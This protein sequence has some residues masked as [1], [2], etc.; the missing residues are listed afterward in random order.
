MTPQ[1]PC[2]PKLDTLLARYL[3]RRTDAQ[4]EGVA[5]FD[6]GE[7]TPYDSG[8]VQPVDAKLAWDEAKAAISAIA[9]TQGGAATKAPAGWSQL[10][11]SHEPVV[12]LALCVGN[13]P[14]LVRNFHQILHK[15]DLTQLRP[16]AGRTV[17]IP[18]VEA[19][20]NKAEASEKTSQWLLALG[21][22]RLSKQFDAADAFIERNESRIP[23][24]DRAA[25]ENE[26]A[27]LAWHRGDA[28]KAYDIWARQEETV[29]VLFNRGM[30]DLFLGRPQSAR[31]ALT[32]AVAQMP[33]AGAWHHL[34]QLYLTLAQAR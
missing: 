9:R 24:D 10:V 14:Q 30:A 6:V 17:V 11:A 16:Q 23:T 31:I 29:A 21:V 27:A 1:T 4:R 26:K 33:E 8:P 25:W 5:S 13:Y 22:L 32:R 34:A 7:V 18:G 19:W 12:A 20:V 15:A 2:Q 28:E 3:Q